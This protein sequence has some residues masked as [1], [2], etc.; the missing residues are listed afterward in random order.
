MEMDMDR[1]QTFKIKKELNAPVYSLEEAEQ[2]NHFKEVVL[3]AEMIRVLQVGI[4]WV[5]YRVLPIL[6]I[7]RNEKSFAGSNYIGK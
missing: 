6:I 5:A 2:M 3:H 7:K 4:T 1:D